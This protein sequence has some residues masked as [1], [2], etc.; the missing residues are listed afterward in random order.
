M[1]KSDQSRPQDRAITC[2]KTYT[3][4]VHG[5]VTVTGIWHGSQWI[6][7]VPPPDA[8]TQSTTQSIVIRYTPADTGDWYDELADTRD[9]FYDAIADV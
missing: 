3:H 9:S 4:E 2:G 1:S 5:R 8:D 6:E 7:T